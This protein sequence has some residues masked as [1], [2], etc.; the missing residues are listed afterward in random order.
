M[1]TR[2]FGTI[3]LAFMLV[4]MAI[5]PIVSAIEP[6]T[7]TLITDSAVSTD[8]QHHNIPYN[9]L[10]NSQPAKFL[11]ESK[12][13]NIIISQKTLE[14]SGQNE[15]SALIKIPAEYLDLNSGF[16]KTTG[17]TSYYVEKGINSNDGI[18]LLRMPTQ[19]YNTFIEES[20][21]EDLTL[22]S[23]Y[24]Y[25]FYS[26]IDDLNSHM[27][28]DNE[29][30]K[31]TPSSQY[32]VAGLLDDGHNLITAQKTALNEVSASSS[33]SLSTDEWALLASSDYAEYLQWASATKKTS[34]NYKYCIGQIRPY[35]WL[36]S[37]SSSDLFKLFAEREYKF[38]NNEAIEMVASFKDR[39]SGGGIR[40]YPAYYRSGS[41]DPILPTQWYYYPEPVVIDPN[42]IPHAYGYHVQLA[43]SGQYVQVNYEDMET[44]QWTDNFFVQAA[45]PISSFTQLDGSSEYTQT[46]APSTGTFSELTSPVID[47]WLIDTGNNWAKPIDV[48]NTPTPSAIRPYV[49]VSTSWDGYGNLITVSSAHYP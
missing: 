32:P 6:A 12:M 40:L 37:G 14:K 20:H 13:T 35:S 7:N 17:S 15:K 3:L 4:M 48:W 11:P 49:N 1:K 23:T 27:I 26:N 38:S 34:T 33:T 45:T 36:L 29:S 24:F 8:V 46:N 5:I 47:E 16:T 31:I 10:E 22:P 21:G 18:V 9:Y 19:F 30:V 2:K 42:D 43:Y 28:K 41:G 25:R 44:F 39:N